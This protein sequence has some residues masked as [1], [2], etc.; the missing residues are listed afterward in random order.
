MIDALV[1]ILFIRVWFLGIIAPTIATVILF[2]KRKPL[3]FYV[4]II[5][6]AIWFIA[7]VI[8]LW[9]VF[10]SFSSGAESTAYPLDIPLESLIMF[11]TVALALVV[12][13]L[14]ALTTWTTHKILKLIYR[15]K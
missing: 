11:G 15:K 2:Y 4:P 7:Q 8:I 5:S 13:L 12:L 10:F 9:G 14:S 3:I 6:T 1:D